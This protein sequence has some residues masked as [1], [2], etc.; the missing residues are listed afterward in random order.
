[1]LQIP[2]K[3]M[4]FIEQYNKDNS[5]CAVAYFKKMMEDDEDTCYNEDAADD[6]FVEHIGCETIYNCTKCIFG[7]NSLD[8]YTMTCLCDV[9]IREHI[10]KDIIMER[11]EP[12]LN[13]HKLNLL[14]KLEL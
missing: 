2:D 9:D 4:W 3:A 11:L 14:D 5:F 8:T 10:P 12:L 13:E 6:F 7:V 1:M